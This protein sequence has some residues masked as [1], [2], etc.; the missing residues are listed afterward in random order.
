MVSSP[1]GAKSATRF[2]KARVERRE[3]FPP[4]VEKTRMD[5]SS[6]VATI[7]W[8]P[9]S[10]VASLVMELL[11]PPRVE[12]HL[13]VRVSLVS[14]EVKDSGSAVGSAAGAS[15]S[16]FWRLDEGGAGEEEPVS[17]AGVEVSEVGAAGGGL[18]CWRAA[19][20]AVQVERSS[21]VEAEKTWRTFEVA[22]YIRSDLGCACRRCIGCNIMGV[23]RRW[24]L[25]DSGGEDRVSAIHEVE[26]FWNVRS[27][28]RDK[29]VELVG[30]RMSLDA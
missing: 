25:G 13:E 12:V 6:E 2:G 30:L 23:W 18:G 26:S 1:S 3:S 7:R 19:T 29:R 17:G 15:G 24:L 22:V 8:D 11:E 5:L 21:P 28:R 27:E 4:E 10:V 16:S 20:G 14:L 9:S